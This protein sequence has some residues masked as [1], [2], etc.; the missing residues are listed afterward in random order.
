MG[1]LTKNGCRRVY[2]AAR[3]LLCLLGL[4]G[5]VLLATGADAR[6]SPAPRASRPQPGL[7]DKYSFPDLP[8][9]S[10]TVKR[11]PAR[12]HTIKRPNKTRRFKLPAQAKAK[13]TRTVDGAQLALSLEVQD[14]ERPVS[15]NEIASGIQWGIK[16][17]GMMD[18]VI[19]KKTG[20]TS[21]PAQTKQETFRGQPAYAV[22]Y[23]ITDSQGVVTDTRERHFAGKTIS[24]DQELELK[25]A[26][27]TARA[28][29]AANDGWQKLSA[30]LRVVK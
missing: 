14:W 28:K 13:Y 6:Q 10:R 19:T 12:I 3:W 22:S 17:M 23:I 2:C 5:L 27:I 8:G 7:L 18:G 25:G 11:L 16:I 24:Y 29:A 4:F 26:P 30:G 20:S 15:L 21:T 9:W 1:A